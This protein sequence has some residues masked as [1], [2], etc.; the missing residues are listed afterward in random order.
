MAGRWLLYVGCALAVGMA[1]LLTLAGVTLVGL[2]LATVILGLEARSAVDPV[3]RALAERE[4]RRQCDRL[5]FC[6]CGDGAGRPTI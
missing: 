2:F 1:A 3:E 5:P 4:L 6:D